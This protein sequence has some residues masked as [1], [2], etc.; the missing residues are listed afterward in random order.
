L[1]QEI[2]L[3]GLNISTAGKQS[4]ILGTDF[5]AAS[6]KF[7]VTEPTTAVAAVI[8]DQLPARLE[9]SM[10]GFPS[11]AAIYLSLYGPLTGQVYPLLL[12]LPEVTAN[13]FGEALA[14]WTVPSGT[15]AGEYAVLI[16]PPPAGCGADR[17]CLKFAILL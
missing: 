17:G 3:N 10:A 16:N 4:A 13:G 12:D 9:I 7:T 15:P 8:T 6:G 5:I 14:G 11:D 2:A 1:H